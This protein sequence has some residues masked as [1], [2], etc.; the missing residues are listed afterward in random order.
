[1]EMY[2]FLA[3]LITGFTACAEFGSFAFVHPVIRRLPPT[4]HVEVEKGLVGTFGRVMPVL[5]TLCA[6]IGI[7]YAI[8][9]FQ[10]GSPDFP[11]AAAAAVSFVA[12]L[13]V[14]VI[15]NVPRNLSVSQWNPEKLPDNW[16]KARNIWEM[17]QG[18][19]ASLLLIGFI[20][21]LAAVSTRIV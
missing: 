21:L 18:V 2:L 6:V 1:M 16:K 5:M 13:I 10:S 7:A 12:S 14:T 20:L 3:L 17:A 11:V 4:H 8:N 9:R 15:A 19:R